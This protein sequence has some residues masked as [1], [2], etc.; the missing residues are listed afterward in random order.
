M[1]KTY[2]ILTLIV[3][4]FTSCEEYLN[5]AP[6]DSPS[7]ETFLQNESELE[8]AVVGCYNSLWH[9]PVDNLPFMVTLEAASDIGWDRNGSDLQAVGKGVTNSDNT[10]TAGFWNSFYRGIGRCNYILDKAPN[11]ES[12]MNTDKYNL[13]ISEVRFL[14]AYYYSII[15]ELF[16]GVPLLTKSVGLSESQIPRSSKDQVTDF[17]LSEL[18][19]A[20]K[21]LLLETKGKDVGRA[22]KGTALSLKSRVALY[23]NRWTVAAQAAQAVMDMKQYS[24]YNNYGDLF[25]YKGQTATEIIWTVRYQKGTATTSMARCFY[26]RMALGHSNKIPVQTLVDSYESIDGLTI[27][28]SPLF[29]PAKP[30]ERRDPR[31]GFTVVVPQSL[32]INLIFDT[33]KDSLKTWDYTNTPP[34]RINNTEAT[35]AYATFSGYLW[36]KYA[37]IADKDDRD[38]CEIDFILFRYAEILLNYAEAKIEANQI[39]Q[40]VYDAINT[41]RA[42][43]SVNM[44]VIASGKTQSELRSIIRKERKYE[45]AGEGFRLFDIR[46]WHIAD[47]VMAGDLLGRVPNGYLSSAPV[48]DEN[49]TPNY[50]SVANKSKMRIIEIRLFDKTKD[51]LWPIPRLEKEVNKVLDQNPNY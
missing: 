44:P 16:G 1:K 23:N 6:L 48:I 15:N 12:K 27:D 28:K 46:R 42:R 4:F 37:D 40:S 9:H 17:I 19:E 35:H 3:V 29:N 13:L 51:Y 39:D 18:D 20:A 41:V 33:N 30:F 50:S 2:I 14:R 5:K 11:L 34:K 26:S 45:L 21:Y 24:L 8:M 32:F 7:D 31:L 10:Y 49:G 47:K 36:R 25:L 38:N 43:P 22:T